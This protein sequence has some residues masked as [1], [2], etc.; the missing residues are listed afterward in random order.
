MTYTSKYIKKT[1]PLL[2]TV[3]CIVANTANV[4]AQSAQQVHVLLQKLEESKVDTGRINILQQLSR[5]YVG[6][7][8]SIA[9]DLDS[10]DLLNDQAELLSKKIEYK[11]GIGRSSFLKGKILWERQNKPKARELFNEALAYSKQYGLFKLSADIDVTLGQNTSIEGRDIDKKNSYFKEALLFYRKAGAKKEEGDVLE[12]LGD[13]AQMKGDFGKSIELLQESLKVYTAIGYRGLQGDYE[14]LCD[15]YRQRG[16]FPLA[17]HNGLLAVKTAEDY[18]DKNEPTTSIYNRVALIYYDLKNNEMALQYFQKSRNSAILAKDTASIFQLS[19]NMSGLLL[20]TGKAG[21]ALNL[22]KATQK[23]YPPKTADFKMHLSDM[24]LRCY[25]K[26]QRYDLAKPYYE[27]MLGYFNQSAGSNDPG[28]LFSSRDVAE[29]LLA[30]GQYQ[31][32][33]PYI[34]SLQVLALKNHNVITQSQ[35]E[36]DY[37]KADSGIGKLKDAIVH[38]QQY[39]RLNDTLFNTDKTRQFAN[40]QLQFETEKKD[41]D[42]QLLKKEGLLQQAIILREKATRNIIIGGIILL[43][44]LLVLAYNRYRF[45]QRSNIALQKKQ[46]EI[47]VQNELLKKLLGEKEWLIKEIH[48]RVKNNL[49]IVI[50][51]LN[52][53]SAYLDNEDALAA[54]KNS[55]HRMHA[56]SLIHQKLYQSDNLACIDMD[57]Y[58]HELVGYMRESFDTDKKIQFTL[59]T[60]KIALD[61]VQA[62][63]LGLIL[64]EAI[65]NAI[66][67]AFPANSYG[68]IEIVFKALPDMMCRLAVT[69]NGIGLPEGFDPETT[70]SLGMSLMKG[71]S[72]QLGGRFEIVNERPGLSFY[73]CFKIFTDNELKLADN[74]MVKMKQEG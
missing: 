62:V 50:S 70:G 4:V 37:F 11:P 43:F 65:S 40:L 29:Y 24:L 23:D 9:S 54:I 61:V 53:Q 3:S 55:Q 19:V 28:R 27:Q 16:D 59:D 56:M 6:K 39:K 48:H 2:L 8:G 66:K 26:L 36:L 34:D 38:Y 57:W 52:T 25:L 12:S 31:Q 21:E 68:K 69:D 45:K 71:L 1:W 60:E 10:A 33:L 44:L 42:I 32:A 63:P 17:L 20:R 5:Y 14:L 72:E 74:N 41:K 13:I 15:V 18:G 49:Q 35:T 51:L 47:N 73:I 22:L 30:I 64:N 58:I 46:D 7:V 67:Y